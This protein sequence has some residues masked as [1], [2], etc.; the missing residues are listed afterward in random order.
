MDPVL[1]LVE[2]EIMSPWAPLSW[3]IFSSQESKRNKQPRS[4]F[5]LRNQNVTN[6][7][8]TMVGRSQEPFFISGLGIKT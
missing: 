2:L 6:C 7:G 5:H 8:A 3:F 1:E 4:F